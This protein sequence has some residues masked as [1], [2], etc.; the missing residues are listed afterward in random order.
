MSHSS[1]LSLLWRSRIASPNAT[2]TPIAT[3]RSASTV[4]T[5]VSRSSSRSSPAT[6]IA[7]PCVARSC[8][9]VSSAERRAGH[10]RYGKRAEATSSQDHRRVDHPAKGFAPRPYGWQCAR[11]RRSGEQP[12]SVEPMLDQ[13]CPGLRRGRGFRDHTVAT[14]AEAG[15]DAAR[16]A[17]TNAREAARDPRAGH[18]GQRWYRQ[19]ARKARIERRRLNGSQ[20]ATRQRR[21]A[22]RSRPARAETGGSRRW[23]SDSRPPPARQ[24]AIRAPTAPHLGR[25]SR[26][27]GSGDTGEVLRWSP[28]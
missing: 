10:C 19:A 25:T 23:R 12:N 4:S 8:P 13:P 9:G 2:P 24:F 20:R 1:A 28:R 15:F 5:S 21:A 27:D 26:G 16:K 6:T 17:I 18:D 3:V 7:P 11:S 14:I 22:S